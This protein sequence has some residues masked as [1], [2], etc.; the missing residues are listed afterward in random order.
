M[1]KKCFSL[2][3]LQGND[4]AHLTNI[5]AQADKNFPPSYISDGNTGTFYSMAEEF[6][7]KLNSLH[8]KNQLN[9]YS[10]E[11]EVLLHSFET[12]SSSPSAQDN[13]EKLQI[14]LKDILLEKGY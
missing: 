4:I 9:L 7:E 6:H 13:M 12:I 2:W 14:F 8:V 5:I 10:K 1:W 3:F 11:K